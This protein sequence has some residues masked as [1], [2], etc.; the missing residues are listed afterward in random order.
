ML[1]ERRM[2]TF[3]TASL[4]R[5]RWGLRSSSLKIWFSPFRLVVKNFES[6]PV[7][8]FII[9]KLWKWR[10]DEEV[11][12]A[13]CCINQGKRNVKSLCKR[14]FW[15]GLTGWLLLIFERYPDP[16]CTRN[17]A[18]WNSNYDISFLCFAKREE[19]DTVLQYKTPYKSMIGSFRACLL[20]CGIMKK[21]SL[22]LVDIS[23]TYDKSYIQDPK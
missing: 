9:Q 22:L 7:A 11:S 2:N 12:V 10:G 23:W 1:Y 6:L 8:F 16:R 20:S 4:L 15:A 19:T 5:S 21:M 18:S 3:L 13:K 14:I 17:T